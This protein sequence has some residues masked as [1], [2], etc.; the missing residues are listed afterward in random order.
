MVE[1]HRVGSAAEAGRTADRLGYPVVLKGRARDVIH[2]TDAGLV[3]LGLADRAG[4]RAAYAELETRLAELGADESGVTVEPLERGLELVI[5]AR[6]DPQFGLVTVVGLGGIHVELM[7][8]VSVRVGRVDRATARAML[9]ETLAGKLLGGV[10][11]GPPLDGY[12]A[13]DAVAALSTLAASLGDSLQSIEVNP[14][15]VRERG[16]GVVGIDAV[17][18]PSA[19]GEGGA[20]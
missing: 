18:V 20:R 1:S 10:R 2:K 12:A 7:A 6:R 17:L 13:A 14:L 9:A 8:E 19:T 5:G 11:G 16:H 4:V 3:R 15:L